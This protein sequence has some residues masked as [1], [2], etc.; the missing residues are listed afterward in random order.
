MG[1][2]L[3]LLNVAKL[4]EGTRL[5]TARWVVIQHHGLSNTSMLH[6]DNSLGRVGTLPLIQL[7]TG[8]S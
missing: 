3:A 2:R 1:S 6:I 7:N 4:L 8:E 5:Y